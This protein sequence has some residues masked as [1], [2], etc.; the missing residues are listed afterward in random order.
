MPYFKVSLPNFN[1]GQEV[2]T[3]VEAV[4]AETA[5]YY[6]GAAVVSH[7]A[8]HNPSSVSFFGSY[9]GLALTD[10]T[11]AIEVTEVAEEDV[12]EANAKVD[13]ILNCPECD[14]PDIYKAGELTTAKV[15]IDLFFGGFPDD[16]DDMEQEDLNDAELLVDTEKSA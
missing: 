15:L 16:S 11:S 14:L 12:F 8:D 9:F 6:A 2:H 4:N 1:V 13:V 5:A 10:E 7:Y 3:V